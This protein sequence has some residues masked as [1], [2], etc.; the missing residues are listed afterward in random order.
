MLITVCAISCRLNPPPSAAWTELFNGRDL[1]G[2][3]GD[4]KIWRVKDGNISGQ[5]AQIPQNTFL[6]YKSSFDDFI[7]E[8][9][10]MLVRS[11]S[12][13]NS[14]IQYRSTVLDEQTWRVAGYQADVGDGYWGPCSMRRVGE[15]SGFRC[16]RSRGRSSRM[17]GISSPS[18]QKVSGS[19]T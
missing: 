10:V 12:F 15:F 2:W 18:S 1:N 6:I 16:P 11:G 13:P 8:A 17:A 7:L 3:D 19:G 5:A 4:P 9:K 14:G